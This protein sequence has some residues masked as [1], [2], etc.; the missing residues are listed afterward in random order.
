MEQPEVV[1]V[2]VLPNKVGPNDLDWSPVSDGE[3]R[4]IQCGLSIPYQQTARRMARMIR[5]LQGDPN[6]DEI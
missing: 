6:P 2:P 3:I 1:N 5:V 4:L